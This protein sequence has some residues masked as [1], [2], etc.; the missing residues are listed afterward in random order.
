MQIIFRTVFAASLPSACRDVP[1]GPQLFSANPARAIAQPCP[2]ASS[3]KR[4]T[5]PNFALDFPVVGRTGD[6]PR[7]ADSQETA[8]GGAA[9]RQVSGLSRFGLGRFGFGGLFFPLQIGVVAF[10]FFDFIVLF[11]HTSL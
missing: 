3:A 5:T 8:P 7:W 9:G 11:A 10:P 4:K 1:S 6:A 2:A